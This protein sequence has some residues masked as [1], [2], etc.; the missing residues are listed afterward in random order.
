MRDKIVA[1]CVSVC[2]VTGSFP[3]LAHAQPAEPVSSSPAPQAALV[4]GVE[5]K[6][7][8]GYVLRDSRWPA[9]Q[10]AV[11]WQD[12]EPA[13][14]AGRS[15]V[16]RAV[17]DSWEANSEIRFTGWG[18]CQ[19]GSRG[20][21][22]EVADATPEVQSLGRFLDNRPS[23]MTLNFRFA[24][25]WPKN[26]PDCARTRDVCLRATA[27]HEFGHALGF[28]H[29]QNRPDAPDQCGELRQGA[30]GDYRVTEYDPSSIM[31]YCN[32]NWVGDGKPSKLD[33]SAL[34]TFY[35]EA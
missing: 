6:E 30:E 8:F 20:I 14:A 23:G 21:K 4:A 28:S 17:K 22:I 26:R 25:W 10:I 9:K 32:A 2:L 13:D 12:F 24:N 18:K 15:I 29:E 34:R 11:C 7:L 33:I 3:S 16:Q 35:G 31:N 27:V 5:N 1:A 19:P